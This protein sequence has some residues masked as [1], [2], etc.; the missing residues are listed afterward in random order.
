[1]DDINW[2]P[3]ADAAVWIVCAACKKGD[4][5]A[6]GPRHFD[7]VMHA[8]LQALRIATN[9]DPDTFYNGWDQ[10]FIDQYG[11][12]YGREEAYKIVQENGQRFFPDGCSG[13]P[14]LFSEGL[15]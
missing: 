7:G 9:A 2:E 3:P 13:K 10:G 15:Y 11:R 12:F 6:A 1:M 14:I 4:F 8:Q 5:I